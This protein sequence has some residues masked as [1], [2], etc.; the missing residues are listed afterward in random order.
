MPFGTV[1]LTFVVFGD[2]NMPVRLAIKIIRLLFFASLIHIC[3]SGTGCAQDKVWGDLIIPL[4]DHWSVDKIDPDD[5]DTLIIQSDQPGKEAILDIDKTPSR[6]LTGEQYLE[7]LNTFENNW[8]EAGFEGAKFIRNS[9][10]NV[11]GVEESPY[12]VGVANGVII[13]SFIPHKRGKV[14]FIMVKVD[15]SHN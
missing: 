9:T 7:W 15:G 6:D 4:S 12:G 1:D 2:W 3:F 10:I 8:M 5:P 11:L 13:Y 14:Y